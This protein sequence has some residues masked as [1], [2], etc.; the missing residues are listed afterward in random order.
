[1]SIRGGKHIV[2]DGKLCVG[3]VCIQTRNLAISKES[4][5]YNYV[6]LPW[7]AEP[8]VP[9]TYAPRVSLTGALGFELDWAK[10]TRPGECVED[11]GLDFLSVN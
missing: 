6:G 2:R 4:K 3:R 7:P 1:M 10:L 5:Q 9:S 11:S 8:K